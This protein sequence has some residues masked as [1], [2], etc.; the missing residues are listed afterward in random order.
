MNRPKAISG[1]AN[2]PGR[3]SRSANSFILPVHDNVKAKTRAF[4]TRRPSVASTIRDPPIRASTSPTTS[5]LEPDTK[6]SGAQSS[7]DSSEPTSSIA[8]VALL[9]KLNIPT[10][11]QIKLWQ[12]PDASCWQARQ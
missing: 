2:S 12:R 11:E 5:D 10:Q 9:F 3:Q 8:T 7:A 4:K 6:A 1:I